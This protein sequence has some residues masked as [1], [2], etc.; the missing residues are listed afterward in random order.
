MSAFAMAVFFKGMTPEE[1]KWLTQAMIASG[2]TLK[3]SG[4]KP[5]V[6]KHSTGG[7]GDKISIPLAPLLACCRVQVPD[8]LR[9]RARH[10]RRHV[11]QT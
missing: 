5:S 4:S 11:G 10:D 8:D 6:D 7:I 9:T 1:T 2:D 3:W